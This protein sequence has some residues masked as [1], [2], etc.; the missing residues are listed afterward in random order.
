MARSKNGQLVPK[1]AD[2]G[3][4]GSVRIPEWNDSAAL[5]SAFRNAFSS[6]WGS[7][8]LGNRAGFHGISKRDEMGS[9][10]LWCVKRARAMQLIRIEPLLHRAPLERSGRGGRQ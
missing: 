8:P 10:V 2:S 1:T 6:L 5:F 7:P 4:S 3:K 9:G